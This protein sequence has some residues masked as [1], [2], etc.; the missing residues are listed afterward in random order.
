MYKPSTYRISNRQAFIVWIIIA[1]IITSVV[2]ANC[3][4]SDFYFL[5]LIV[6]LFSAL[7]GL[8]GTVIIA[9]PSILNSLGESGRIR[10]AKAFDR[11]MRSA[12]NKLDNGE[13]IE[14]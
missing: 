1:T 4:I 7:L 11:Q 13:N 9:L 6:S 5:S 12:Y 14:R 8:I 10:N 2:L 3:V